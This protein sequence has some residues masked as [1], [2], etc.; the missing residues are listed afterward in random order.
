MA[1]P[2]S[3]KLLGTLAIYVMEESYSI[4]EIRDLIEKH[5]RSAE[6]GD[7]PNRS[8]QSRLDEIANEIRYEGHYVGGDS[9]EARKLLSGFGADNFTAW[10]LGE[11]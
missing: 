1:I 11:Y 9:D 2:P 6:Q 3:T 4:K 7:I 10:H 5:R 8:L